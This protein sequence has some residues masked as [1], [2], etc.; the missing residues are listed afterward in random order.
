MGFKKDIG[1]MSAATDNIL[2]KFSEN[3]P[4]VELHRFHLKSL[5]TMCFPLGTTFIAS[6]DS[7]LHSSL[8]LS[9]FRSH[10]LFLKMFIELHDIRFESPLQTASPEDQSE[11]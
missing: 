11:F 6:T 10:T 2:I 7:K 5:R 8:S 4:Q 1:Q 3:L 9:S